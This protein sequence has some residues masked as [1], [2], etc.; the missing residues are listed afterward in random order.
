MT[1]REER[2]EEARSIITL[3][4]QQAST[5]EG[6]TGPVPVELRQ[7]LSMLERGEMSPSVAM[8]TAEA[9]VTCGETG[10]LKDQLKKISVMKKH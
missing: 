3:M 9:L 10:I 6:P 5:A 7:I 4:L 1:A 8:R 2:M